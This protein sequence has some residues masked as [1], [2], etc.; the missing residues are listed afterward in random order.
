MEIPGGSYYV[1]KDGQ[2][3]IISLPAN[4]HYNYVM[5]SNG[6]KFVKGNEY[7]R[8]LFQI[9]SDNYTQVDVT[10]NYKNTMEC[11]DRALKKQTQME[12]KTSRLL[13]NFIK[14][15]VRRRLFS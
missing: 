10:E 4:T 7:V 3:K 9:S 5:E 8:S 12:R 6:F 14:R 11:L 13:K 2:T 1:S 15:I